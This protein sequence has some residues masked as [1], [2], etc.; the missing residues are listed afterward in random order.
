ML[1]EVPTSE[2]QLE[3]CFKNRDMNIGIAT[4][5]CDGDGHFSTMDL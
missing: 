5:I 2:G 1:T 4:I 3:N